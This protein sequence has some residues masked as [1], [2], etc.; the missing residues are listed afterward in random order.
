MLSGWSYADGQDLADRIQYHG[1][2]RA[3]VREVSVL[4]PVLLVVATR[5]LRAPRIRRIL[6]VPQEED[7]SGGRVHDGDEER[8]V[9]GD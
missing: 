7:G 1:F 9:E 5:R 8:A 3:T 2:A 4:N 6:D